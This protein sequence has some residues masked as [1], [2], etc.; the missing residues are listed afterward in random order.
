MPG[1]FPGIPQAQKSS[2]IL[3]VLSGTA[4][5]PLSL[6]PDAVITETK[7]DIAKSEAD[8]HPPNP[9]QVLA[10]ADITVDI[11]SL[12]KLTGP[13]VGMGK[14]S[15]PRLRTKLRICPDG[16]RNSFTRGRNRGPVLNVVVVLS[17]ERANKTNDKVVF[18]CIN[19]SYLM[20]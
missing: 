10:G 3:G 15:H 13:S 4:F 8:D 14:T 16:K 1:V 20:D 7:E 11:I 6:I 9:V 19:T 17:D 2:R 5:L 18:Y 12:T